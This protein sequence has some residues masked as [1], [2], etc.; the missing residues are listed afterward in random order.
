MPK[1]ENSTTVV[2]NQ[3]APNRARILNAILG[4]KDA[5]LHDRRIGELLG[6]IDP[7]RI[8]ITE[9]RRFV[10]RAITHLAARH[11]IAQIVELGCGYPTTPS[12]HDIAQK[13]RDSVKTLFVD[14][15]LLV[16]VHARALLREPGNHVA[17]VDLTDTPTILEHIDTVMDPAQPV[18][19]CLS[20]SLEYLADAPAVLAALTNG[21]PAGSWLVLSH[22]TADVF[23]DATGAAVEIFG[24][25]GIGLH[26]RSRDEITTML[27][28]YRLLAPGLVAPHLWRPTHDYGQPS[29]VMD[30]HPPLLAS[31]AAASY[32]AVGCLDSSDEILS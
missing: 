17:H 14:S 27:A 1:T 21:L 11:G 16:T 2:L 9:S 4:R 31:T 22:I 26:P 24:A 20:G 6:T 28:P 19:V 12:L 25:N 23:T 10:E 5:E 7:L 13:H 29:D 32:V 3:E 18:A 8:A 30:E 15:D